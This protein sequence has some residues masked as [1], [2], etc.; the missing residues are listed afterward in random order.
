MKKFSDFGIKPKE[1]KM[2]EAKKI[3]INDILNCEIKVIDYHKDVTTKNGPDRYVVKIM[4]DNEERKFFTNCNRI[5]EELSQIPKDGFPFIATIK[6][7]NLGGNARV[8]Y[9]T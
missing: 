9:F 1:T 7:K 4:F 5:K 3:S 2:F 6:Q 8:Y